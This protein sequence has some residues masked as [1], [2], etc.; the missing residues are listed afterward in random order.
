M[1]NTKRMLIAFAVALV[2]SYVYEMLVFQ[3]AL[4]DFHA[5]YP[6]WLKAQADLHLV[7]MLLTGALNMALITLFYALFARNRASSL[8]TGLVYGVLLGLIAGWVPQAFNRLL[9]VDYPFYPIWAIAIF[10]EMVV[11]GAVLGLVYREQA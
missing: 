8:S 2:V 3:M 6:N 10:G 4:G 9:F 5:R 11:I 1:I 7:R